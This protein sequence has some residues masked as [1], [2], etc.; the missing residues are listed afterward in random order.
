MAVLGRIGCVCAMIST[1]GFRLRGCQRRMEGGRG[2]TLGGRSWRFPL[3]TILPY[4]YYAVPV[5]GGYCSR[6][7]RNRISPHD[8]GTHQ[9]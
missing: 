6:L 4:R 1:C 2:R 7:Y 5:D 9:L 3:C 8:L